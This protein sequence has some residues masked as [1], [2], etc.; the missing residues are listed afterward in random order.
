MTSDA[1]SE[2]F[3]KSM[4]AGAL[5]GLIASFA[6]NQYQAAVSAVGESVARRERQRK[7]LPEP[8]RDEQGSGDD[9]TIRAANAVSTTI[10]NR[11][12]AEDEKKWAGPLVHYGLGTAL[13]AFYG[14]CAS[15]LPVDSRTAMGYGA[16]VWIGADEIAVPLAGLSG[17]PTETPLSGHL[18]ALAS[19]LV[20]GAVTH[21]T[22][23][24]VLS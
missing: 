15:A 12:L 6:M 3:W 13:G 11:E 2:S 22:R 10:L 8:E 17:P 7:G 21:L 4:A 1:G 14:A 5:G 20:Y 19:H 24:L 18:N 9:A 16:A 23:K